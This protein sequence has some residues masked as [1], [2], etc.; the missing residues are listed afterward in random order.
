MLNHHCTEDTHSTCNGLTRLEKVALFSPHPT[1]LYLLDR[2]NWL[3]SDYSTWKY[4]RA[5]K[6]QRKTS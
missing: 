6:E 3:I 1:L 2:E 5:S 4:H